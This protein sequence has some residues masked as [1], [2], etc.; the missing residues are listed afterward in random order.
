MKQSFS[1]RWWSFFLIVTAGILFVV[2]DLSYSQAGDITWTSENYARIVYFRATSKKLSS[3]ST[4]S[5]TISAVDNYV[6]YINGDSV[7]TDTDGDW[8]TAESWTASVPKGYCEIAVKVINSGTSY[9]G[10]GFMIDGL[11]KKEEIITGISPQWRYTHENIAGWTTASYDDDRWHDATLG[12]INNL[13]LQ[14]IPDFSGTEVLPVWDHVET[15]SPAVTDSGKVALVPINRGLNM[16]LGKI[17]LDLSGIEVERATDGETY[18]NA[19]V[20]NSGIPEAQGYY[21]KIDL[22]ELCFIDH[23]RI[24]PQNF[25]ADGSKPDTANYIKGY[26]VRLS[27]DDIKYKEVLINIFNRNPVVDTTFTPTLARYVKVMVAAV[28]NINKVVIGEIEVFGTGYAKQGSFTS[29]PLDFGIAED[30]NFG[31]VKWNAEIPSD[32]KLDLQFRTGS[33]VN[34]P[35]QWEWCEWSEPSTASGGVGFPALEPRRYFQYRANLVSS[36]PKITPRLHE[37]TVYYSTTLFANSAL[38]SI[39]AVKDTLPH[40]IEVGVET[41]FK[42]SLS[43]Q[44]DEKNIG[45]DKLTILSPTKCVV[46]S[47]DTN[48]VALVK[49]VDFRDSTTVKGIV[50]YFN[51]PLKHTID[52]LNVYFRTTLFLDA[53]DFPGHITHTGLNPGNPQYLEEST[54]GGH[55]WGINTYGYVEKVLDADRVKVAPNPFSPNGDGIF[56][57]T[58]IEFTIANLSEPRNISLK[59]FNLNGSVVWKRDMFRSADIYKEEWNGINQDGELVLPGLYIY[60][61]NVDADKALSPVTG[62]ITVVY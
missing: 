9:E 45:F 24:L 37:V 2:S 4:A 62:T 13:T 10:S 7:G 20:W 5:F 60:Q 43:T 16:A 56:D 38:G 54:T 59:I 29:I 36:D 11:V 17:A 28:D 55:S 25:A 61:I 49:G 1:A 58:V 50:L 47:V 14:S 40:E 32:T 35:D 57:Y 21:L 6:L 27:R 15:S 53:N 46:D 19:T 48:G 8:K 26:S 33:L 12:S 39:V 23:I 30:K 52:A 18:G 3:T 22:D 34:S 41:T 42:Y 44:L 31:I 51:Q